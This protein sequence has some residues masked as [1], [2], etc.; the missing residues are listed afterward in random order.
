MFSPK[1]PMG[2]EPAKS[3][4]CGAV[5]VMVGSLSETD[6]VTSECRLRTA[7]AARRCLSGS[8]DRPRSDI[9]AR[10]ADMENAIKQRRDRYPL[11]QCGTGKAAEKSTSS[12]E[13]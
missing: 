5:S 11:D 4:H 2:I 8:R 7:I 10:V 13:R 1:L 6:E 12:P 9:P 3:A